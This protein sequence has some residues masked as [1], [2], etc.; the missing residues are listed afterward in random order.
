MRFPPARQLAAALFALLAV[1]FDT[2]ARPTTPIAPRN[3]VT[4]DEHFRAAAEAYA[5]G[6]A[7]KLASEAQSL[8]GYIL[9]P[10]VQ[11][12]QLVLRLDSLSAEQV[13]DFLA[14]APGTLLAEQLRRDWLK[15]LAK[16]G[17]WRTFEIEYP[18]AVGEDVELACYALLGRWRRGDES[19]AE[20]FRSL[21]ATPRDLP[22][23]CALLAEA[24]IAAGKLTTGDV[25]ARTRALLQADQV[26]GAK[27]TIAQLPP[28]E[29]PGGRTID[30]ARSRPA[31]AIDGAGKLDLKKRANRELLLFALTQTAREDAELA[32]THWARLQARFSA[33]DQ[34]WEWG[35]IATQAAR[36]H[37]PRALEWFG[38]AQAVPLPDEQLEWRARAAL[39]DE[40]WAAVRAAVE[41]MTPLGRNEPA[42]IYWYARALRT[43]G[44]RE[45]ADKLF[46]RVAGEHH[47]YGKLALEEIGR[48]LSIPQ[49]GYTPTAADTDEAAA[50]PSLLRALALFRLGMR[51][52]GLREWNWALRDMDDRQLLSAAEFARRNEVWDRAINTADRTIGLH[53]FSVRFLAPYRSAFAEQAKLLQLEEHWLLGLTRQESRFNTTI[54]SPAGAVGLMQVMP[55]TAKW[56]AKRMGMKDFSLARIHEPDVNIALGTNY[57]RFV[58]DEL[59]ASPVLAATAYNAGPGRARKWKADRALEGAI[60]VET[61][62]FSETR[63]YVQRVMSNTVYYAALYGGEAK[64][65]KSRLGVIP[66]RQVGESYEPTITGY[67]E[68]PETPETPEIPEETAVE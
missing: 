1:A 61:I 41:S 13:H 46:R 7:A 54:R 23:G 30:S 51:A 43:L 58:F 12:W 21:W 25:W 5:K 16:R 11:Y 14:R 40:N 17:E 32:A 36:Q 56:V 39:R 52:E 10:Y 19:A 3:P 28:N 66:P 27:R 50:N 62:P 55:R 33:E 64:S 34:A 8:K 42:W 67:P 60:Y 6:N 20:A 26:S 31:R 37:H 49:R 65:L 59:N 57:L 35:Q 38:N 48:P 29:Q 53:D 24:Q 9:E 22:D 44:E 47:Y 45:R 15:S 18:K 63:D 2:A 4:Q 68:T